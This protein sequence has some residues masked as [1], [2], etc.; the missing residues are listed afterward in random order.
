M[1]DA[2]GA[3]AL[4]GR[5]LVKTLGLF[6]LALF[7]PDPLTMWRVWRHRTKAKALARYQARRHMAAVARALFSGSTAHYTLHEDLPRDEDSS[8]VLWWL[9]RPIESTV[10]RLPASRLSTRVKP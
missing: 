3:A 5:G 8:R 6:L 10:S 1:G 7:T 4:G 9:D 2:A